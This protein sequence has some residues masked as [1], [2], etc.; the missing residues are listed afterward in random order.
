MLYFISCTSIR[1]PCTIVWK[2][3]LNKLQYAPKFKKIKNLCA[4]RNAE[5]NIIIRFVIRHSC[6]AS[7]I[8]LHLYTNSSDEIDMKCCSFE[9]L[10]FLKSNSCSYLK[11]SSNC[12]RVFCSFFYQDRGDWGL[13]EQV[14]FLQTINQLNFQDF[15]NRRQY[16]HYISICT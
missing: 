10:M 2:P 15:I 14:D 7:L 3:F 13:M 16:Q 9:N 4:K 6:K 12:L 5:K 11:L 8:I 1:F